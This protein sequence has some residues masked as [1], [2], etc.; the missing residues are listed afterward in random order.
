[1]EL[2]HNQVIRLLDDGAPG[3]YAGGLYR[4]LFDEPVTQKVV[5]VC[6]DVIEAARRNCGGRPLLAMPTRLRKKKRPPLVGDLLWMD[7]DVL[8]MMEDRACLHHV[9][10]EPSAVYFSPMEGKDLEIYDRRLKAM[11]VFLDFDHMKESII[12]HHGLSGLVKEA[13]IAAQ[14]SR[15]FVYVQWSTLCRLGLSA[16]NLRPRHDRCGAPGVRRPCEPSGR[17]KPGRKTIGQRIA[18]HFGPMPE[19]DQPGMNEAW[20]AAIMAADRTIKGPVK[21]KM[22]VRFE[23]IV[24][25][26][27][28]SRYKEKD[29][30]LIRVE[31][32]LGTYPNKEQVRRVLTNEIPDFERLLQSTTQGHFARAMRGLHARNWKGVAGPGHTWAIDSTVG[33]I[34][35]RSSINR[36][37]IIG[38]PIVYV[39][40]DVWSTAIVGF[41]VC[42]SGPSW[43]MARVS[44]FNCVADQ[45][46]LGA[47]WGYEPIL[48]L[49]PA[50]TMCYALMCD[51]GE[52]LSKKASF[53]AAKLIDCMSYA[54]PYRPELKGLVEVLHRIAKDAQYLFV[55]GAI[56][57]RRQEYELRRV[58]P[59]DSAYT[60]QEYCHHLHVVFS[61]YNLCADRTNRLDAHMIG[62]GVVAS[63]AGLWRWGHEVGIGFRK[64][65]PESELITNLLHAGAGHVGRSS[66]RH[67]A[68]DYMSKEVE[69]AHWTT[70]ARNNGGWEIPVHYYPGSHKYIW[71]PN[72]G[73][74]GLLRLSISDQANTDANLTVE[75]RCDAFMYA[76]AKNAEAAHERLM[77]SLRF[78][79]RME[80]IKRDAQRL[81]AEALAKESGVQPTIREARQME[82]MI[83]PSGTV[84]DGKSG[85]A[86]RDEALNTHLDM[87]QSILEAMNED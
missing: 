81:T 72:Q 54:P 44:L 85:E 55:P 75:E 9:S 27:F 76:K 78:V 7:H 87:M 17:K 70:L 79:D 12:L 30:Q 20:R 2:I 19:P 65:L 47:L 6:L 52:Y 39:I 80:S 69:D 64:V 25:S 16:T 82:E 5:V 3:A 26:A 59:Q 48:T 77:K 84:A 4:V 71:T 14:V 8:T 35:L 53:T 46:L 11:R 51:R 1:M 33:D 67:A 15:S 10:V 43:D 66:V 23:H 40:V 57:Q 68:N 74:D 83:I 24:K 86:L 22:R 63:P 41:Y 42:L 38:R 58:R 37:W 18:S 28:V 13:M 21:P 49:S 31:P 45:G 36:A 50:P 73:A 29:G 60:L 62:D 32:E 34:Y 56:D 61:Q